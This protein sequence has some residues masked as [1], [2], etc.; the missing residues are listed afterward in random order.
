MSAS[1]DAACFSCGLIEKYVDLANRFTQDLSSALVVP[2]WDIFLAG[3]GLWVVM[4]AFLLAVGL[5]DIRRLGVEI[6]HVI[7]AA[8]LLSCQGPELVNSLYSLTLTLMGG[9]SSFIFSVASAG[10]HLDGLSTLSSSAAAGPDAMRAMVGLTRV[11]EEGIGK[12]FNT[13]DNIFD[14]ASMTSPMPILY[15]LLLVGPWL[16]IIFHFSSK[17]VVAIFRVIMVSALS[18]LLMVMFAFD[19]GRGM[20]WT[21]LRTLFASFMVLFC[22]TC[23]VA[24]CLYGVASLDLDT[25]E[26]ISITNPDLVAAIALGWMGTALLMT[27]V[28][29][30]N[31]IAGAALSNVAAG[32]LTA[33]MFASSA[34]ATK[35][36]RWAFGR[37]LRAG[38]EAAGKVVRAGGQA[39]GNA[40][41]NAARN[42]HERIKPTF[43]RSP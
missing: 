3:I 14:T 32:M 24:L 30:A 9:A 19:F 4:R 18:P 11:T 5:S 23:A 15:G 6:L 31:S 20:F 22:A 2:M 33:G 7:I 1:P 42:L 34:L 39:L 35:P 41:G 21:G 36:A 17:I 10:T 25:D 38:G 12:V 27:G 26:A 43:D 16:F 8:F 13:T 37:G 28:E 40:V 29:I